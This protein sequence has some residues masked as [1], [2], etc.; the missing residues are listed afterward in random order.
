MLPAT[1]IRRRRTSWIASNE[2]CNVQISAENAGV[3]LQ[4]VAEH[5]QHTDINTT[6]KPYILPSL[7]IAR[8]VAKQ[9]VAHRQ[10]CTS[11]AKCWRA[12]TG[13]AIGWHASDAGGACYERAHFRA[14]CAVSTDR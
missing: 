6:R 4:D 14:A 10:F 2:I 1:R 13:L 9:R 11:R 3:V 5:A 8:R 7:E 12:H